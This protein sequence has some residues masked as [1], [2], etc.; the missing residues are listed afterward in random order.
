MPLAFK[1]LC[2]STLI[3]SSMRQWVEIGTELGGMVQV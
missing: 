1:F 2:I 3:W